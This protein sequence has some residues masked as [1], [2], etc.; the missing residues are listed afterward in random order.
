[1]NGFA[2]REGAVYNEQ[3]RRR[4][5]IRTGILLI[6]L[7][8][9]GYTIYNAVY[10]NG[11]RISEGSKA[12]NFA[13][14]DTEGRLIELSQL[15]GKGVFLNFWERGVSRVSRNFLYGESIQAF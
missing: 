3:K 4:L 8:A 7:C 2:G 13:L 12:P 11:E 6:L 15:K 1:M 5:F 9:L 10:T 14:K